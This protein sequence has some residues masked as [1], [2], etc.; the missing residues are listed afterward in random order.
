M[1][2]LGG[3]F[4]GGE[5]KREVGDQFVWPPSSDRWAERLHAAWVSKQLLHS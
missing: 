3:L 5:T 1:N 4:G 2:I